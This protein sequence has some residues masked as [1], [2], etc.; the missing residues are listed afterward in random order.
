MTARVGFIGLGRMGNP[1]CRHILQAGF[2]LTVYDRQ[3]EAAQ[4]VVI[5]G[6]RAATS[7]SEVARTSAVVL[8][9]VTDDAQ[10]RDVV[11]D[12]M[13]GA[14]PGTVVAVCSSIHPD[15][16]RDLAKECAARGVGFV[17]APVARGERGAEAGE[18][19]TF[20]GGEAEHVRK[21]QPI[22][23]AYSK[24]VFH[25]GAVGAGQ[26]TKTCNNLMHWA[27]IVACYETL[28]LGARLGIAPKDLRPALIAGSVDSRTLRELEL[29]KLTWPEK[30]MATALA[31]AN[32]SE[33]RVPLMENVRE[34][35]KGITVDDLRGLFQ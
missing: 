27:E 5:L 10:V 17:D 6:A 14:Q 30:D 1:M 15:T 32:A 24:H 16:C 8:V 20:V 25:M 23:A 26:I 18:L 11:N 29:V 2:A 3:S 21:C 31:L 35:V 33:T 7:A 9:M 12:V 13:N 34:L 19:T 22:F 4:A 28:S